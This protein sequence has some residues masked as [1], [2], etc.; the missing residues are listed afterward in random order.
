MKFSFCLLMLLLFTATKSNA[1]IADQYPPQWEQYIHQRKE[2]VK[3]L[4]GLPLISSELDPFNS[5]SR[6]GK[7][8][9]KLVKYSGKHFPLYTAQTNQIGQAHHGGIIIIDI[10]K[11]NEPEEILAFWLAHEWGHQDLGHQSN[12]YQPV[13][14]TK[15][16][17]NILPTK[18]EDEA[19]AYAA[20]FLAE[21]DYDIDSVV[22]QL[23]KLPTNPFNHSHSDG[24]LRALHVKKVYESASSDG[25]LVR[26]PEGHIVECTHGSIHPKGELV[27]CQHWPRHGD[28]DLIP[29]QHGPLHPRG[30]IVRCQHF[31]TNPYDPFGRP[32]QVHPGGDL[33]PCTHGAVHR[34][35]DLVPCQHGPAHPR[36]DLISCQHGL[37]HPEGDII[38]CTHRSQ[39]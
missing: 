34:N 11:L 35:G 32:I 8:Y 25:S 1:Q 3:Y 18:K 21:M 33:F 20:K 4:N 15:W 12:I 37:R 10:S 23:S 13:Q 9:R 6:V 14:K 28:G 5:Q 22:Y 36:G 31:V 16:E 19:D 26:H 24:P 2:F 38:P 17:Y 30:D 27:P 39:P 29:C 7:I